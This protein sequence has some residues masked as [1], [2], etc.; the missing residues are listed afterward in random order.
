MVS[1]DKDDDKLM[2]YFMG[3]TNERLLQIEGK[4]VELISFR[5]EVLTEAKNK[6]QNTA[7][8]YAIVSFIITTVVNVV[9]QKVGL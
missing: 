5:A 4:L 9:L 7:I 6:A 3:Q 1:N 8:I 2:V